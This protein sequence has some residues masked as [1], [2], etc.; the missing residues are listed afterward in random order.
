[1][2]HFVRI[3]TH[4]ARTATPRSGRTVMPCFARNGCREGRRR[5]A[6]WTRCS[7][8]SGSLARASWP[9]KRAILDNSSSKGLLG[10]AL[11]DSEARL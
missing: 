3:V 4:F 5:S 1:M 7:G 11:E 9:A 10:L 6:A 8:T 2:T